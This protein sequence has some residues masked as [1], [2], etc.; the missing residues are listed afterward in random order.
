MAKEEAQL[1]LSE[2]AAA[3][4]E[5]R[6][7]LERMREQMATLEAHVAEESNAGA[8]AVADL[9]SSQAE[10]RSNEADARAAIAAAREEAEARGAETMQAK[11]QAE[12]LG[13]QITISTTM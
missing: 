9:N 1:R 13:K 7:E 11:E 4:V 12:A 2:E 6:A 8:K 3:K 10:G 5:A